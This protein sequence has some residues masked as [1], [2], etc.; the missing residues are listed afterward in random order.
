MPKMSQLEK[1]DKRISALI[2]GSGPSSCTMAA[3][4][5]YTGIPA[6]TLKRYRT[7]PGTIPLDNLQR[8]VRARRILDAEQLKI[9]KG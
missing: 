7:R 4:S 9:L 6:T 8:I 5:R 2:F 3:L 1:R